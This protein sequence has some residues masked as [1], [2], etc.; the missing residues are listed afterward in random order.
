MAYSYLYPP[1][2]VLLEWG[3]HRHFPPPSTLIGILIILPAMV[4]VQQGNADRKS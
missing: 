4:L 3:L 2:L 1:L